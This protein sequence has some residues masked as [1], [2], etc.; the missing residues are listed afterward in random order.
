MQYCKWC[1]YIVDDF[2]RIKEDA[3]RWY[4]ADK[5]AFL[6][7]DGNLVWDVSNR[8][9]VMYYPHFTAIAPNTGGQEHSH[10]RNAIRNYE[11]LKEWVLEV[12]GDTPII[13]PT[14]LEH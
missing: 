12:M 1:Y 4:G 5:V 10:F 13:D 7:V 11:T 3:E 9:Q 2:N 6:K 14:F 8:Y